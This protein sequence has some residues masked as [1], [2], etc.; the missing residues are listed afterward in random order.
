MYNKKIVFIAACIG[1]LLFGVVMI[2]I[3]TL[4]PFIMEKFSLSKLDAGALTSLLPLGI[5]TG[6]LVFGPIVDRYGYKPLLIVC[7][8][9]VMISFQQMAFVENYSFI[10]ISVFFIGFGGGI[11]NGGTNALV[12]DI[13]EGGK[14]AN[15]SL[16]GVSFGIGALTM[17]TLLSVLLTHYDY[18]HIISAIGIAIFFPLIFFSVIS[19]P[20]PKL[21]KGTPIKQRLKLIKDP[22]L[23]LFGAILFFQSGLE[24][25]VNNWT[26]SYL[27]SAHNFDKESA[28]LMLTLFVIGLTITR[29]FL[30][31]IL[32]SKNTMM[33]YSICI[34]FATMG[35]GLFVFS[36]ATLILQLAMVFLGIGLSAGFPV[37]LG[38]VG[39]IYA[40]L[41]G[42][43]FSIVLVI[44]LSG[45]VIINYSMGIISASFSIE[46][47]PKLLLGCVIV[48]ATLIIAART[49]ISKINVINNK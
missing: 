29:L 36:T 24:G 37:I 38:F 10:L 19:F 45:N 23:L 47:M 40:K 34:G 22:S 15:L 43:A 18:T 27:I 20:Q 1:M 28:L 4:L 14:G 7:S 32:N 41:S 9:V 46:F 8:S 49:K 39:E 11:L 48:M 35:I 33:V 25:I 12:S 30:G 26:T 16:L 3:G 13:S 17:P 2:S 6:S 21:T 31:F 5:L 44:A 42:T